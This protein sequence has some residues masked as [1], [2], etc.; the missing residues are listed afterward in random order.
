MAN[1]KT[2]IVRDTVTQEAS[3]ALCHYQVRGLSG[4]IDDGKLSVIR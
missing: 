2:V 4:I 1:A 3:P